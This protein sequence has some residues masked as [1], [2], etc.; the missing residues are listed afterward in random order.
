MIEYYTDHS[1]TKHETNGRPFSLMRI[2]LDSLVYLFTH[3]AMTYDLLLQKQADDLS[4]D[5]I[6]FYDVMFGAAEKLDIMKV[7][8]G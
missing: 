1:P 5:R 8:F 2:R 6:L 7:R 4:I 3:A